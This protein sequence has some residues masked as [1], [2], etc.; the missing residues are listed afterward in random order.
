M[1]MHLSFISNN[2]KEFNWGTWAV[3]KSVRRQRPPTQ[4]DFFP[5]GRKAVK[6]AA[7]G[8]VSGVTT[9]PATSL[10]KLQLRNENEDDQGDPITPMVGQIS[11]SLLSLDY[12]EDLDLSWNCLNGSTGRIPK[13]LGPMETLIFFEWSIGLSC[14]VTI[15]R[16][17][18]LF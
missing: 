18:Y 10:I 4:R 13:F 16:D 8:A 14:N 12:L 2:R 3:N 9:G 6:T 17:V 15:T 1:K 11:Q 7:G 5:R